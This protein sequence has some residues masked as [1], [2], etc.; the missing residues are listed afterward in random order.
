MLKSHRLK[1]H[2]LKSHQSGKSFDS[3][4]EVVGNSKD[5]RSAN[6]FVDYLGPLE[7][8]LNR[9]AFLKTATAISLLG[10]L[11]A[12]KPEV[13]K[14]SVASST[15]TTASPATKATTKFLS[16]E[17]SLSLDSVYMQL[18]PDDGNGPSAQDLNILQYLDWAMT[19]P[20]N[21]DDG[22]PEFIKKG[23]GWLNDLAEQTQGD[24]FERLKPEQQDKVL[25]QISR[26]N[27]GENWLSLLLYYLTEA[28][29]LDPV[30]GGN[31]NQIGWQW[32]EHQAGF[33]RPETGKTYRDFD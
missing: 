32:L 31:P 20:Q 10:G 6:A 26:S 29:L 30:Y 11:A 18:F 21:V 25:Q 28:L 14:S 7:S 33:P 9:R 16:A 2:R 1:S 17:E 19:D 12:C 8:G 3:V 4:S 5:N 15:Q 13:P 27:A 23:I 24:R 22:D